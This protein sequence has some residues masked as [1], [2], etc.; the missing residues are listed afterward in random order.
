MIVRMSVVLNRTVV[1]TSHLQRQGKLNTHF[2]SIDDHRQTFVFR[3]TLIHIPLISYYYTHIPPTYEMTRG[4]K[5]FTTPKLV[6]LRK[7]FL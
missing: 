5:A 6:C 2:D 3:V 7:G 4:L 1:D